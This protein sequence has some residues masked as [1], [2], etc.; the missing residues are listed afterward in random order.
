MVKNNYCLKLIKSQLIFILMLLTVPIFSQNEAAEG[1]LSI[2][3]TQADDPDLNN[4]N[5]RE[6]IT[7]NGISESSHSWFW[8]VKNKHSSKKIEVGFRV[9]YKY[10]ESFDGKR[11]PE[12]SDE[13]IE[14]RTINPGQ[15]MIICCKTVRYTSTNN[16]VYISTTQNSQPY[17]KWANFEE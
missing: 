2:W 13:E 10:S 7:K 14:M 3:L 5:K 15:I 6:C 12:V 16:G 17:I 4:V 1:Y 9:P 11:D 8:V